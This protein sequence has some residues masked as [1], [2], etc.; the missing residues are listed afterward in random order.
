MDILA[1]EC[2]AR[3]IV[4]ALRRAGHRVRYAS[5]VMAGFEDTLLLEKSFKEQQLLLTADYDFGDLVFRYN[6]RAFGVLIVSPEF[7]RNVLTGNLDSLV[8]RIAVLGDT[9]IGQLT[10]V[11]SDRTRQRA[12]PRASK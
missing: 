9:L 11:E 2:V 8:E 5:E 1:D 10:I 7:M 4:S 3:D 12:L 6:Q